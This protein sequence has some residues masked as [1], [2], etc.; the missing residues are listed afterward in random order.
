MF[1]LRIY[2]MLRVIW[3][4]TSK[5]NYKLCRHTDKFK[6][7]L[8]SS[9]AFPK[10]NSP[11]HFKLFVCL[12]LYFNFK[13]TQLTHLYQK[14]K[15]VMHKG[16]PHEFWMSILLKFDDVFSHS[17]MNLQ[18]WKFTLH[19][20]DIPIRFELLN[21]LSKLINSSFNNYV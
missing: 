6:F 14:N 1:K 20:I 2:I 16:S 17:L 10:L 4:I 19:E 3:K 5:W 7:S 8:S 15:Y 13:R 21:T 9:Y 11:G 18:D 12:D